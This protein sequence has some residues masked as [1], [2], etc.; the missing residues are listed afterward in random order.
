MLLGDKTLKEMLEKEILKET[1]QEK[2][3]NCRALNEEIT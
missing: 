2:V 1:L 3:N